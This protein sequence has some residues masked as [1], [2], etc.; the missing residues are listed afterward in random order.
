MIFETTLTSLSASVYYRIWVNNQERELNNRIDD[1]PWCGRLRLSN[2]PP[3]GL[4]NMSHLERI[5]THIFLKEGLMPIRRWP[6]ILRDQFHNDLLYDRDLDLR[7]AESCP[8]ARAGLPI[9]IVFDDLPTASGSGEG[10]SRRNSRNERPRTPPHPRGDS[11]DR[12]S[13]RNN[14]PGRR[15]L[16]MSKNSEKG[17]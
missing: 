11:I 17:L 3:P 12:K 7:S 6:R 5:L 16:P 13:W 10:Q 14:G 2:V 4:S 1:D 9:A 15:R 8:G